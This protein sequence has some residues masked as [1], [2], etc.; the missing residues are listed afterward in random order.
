MWI[1]KNVSYDVIKFKTGNPDCSP[2][3][4]FK[5]RVGVCSGY[6]R[7]FSAMCTEVGLVSENIVGYAKGYG[8]IP[9]KK[10]F[11]TNHEWKAIKLGDEYYLVDCCWGSGTVDE[12]FVLIEDL[13]PI[14]S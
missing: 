9:D 13:L 7:L 8:Y 11:S 10:F 1:C 14:F 5:K 12:K 2:E 3:G 4:V 6:A